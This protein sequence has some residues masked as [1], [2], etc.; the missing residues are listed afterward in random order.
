MFITKKMSKGK[1]DM[2]VAL[3]NAV[4]MLNEYEV[5]D[6]EPISWGIISLN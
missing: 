4:Y 2:V 3:I 5:L 1:V 6:S